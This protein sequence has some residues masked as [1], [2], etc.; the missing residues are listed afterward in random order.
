MEQRSAL[1]RCFV[2]EI[3]ELKARPP[4]QPWAAHQRDVSEGALGGSSEH[5]EVCPDPCRRQALAASCLL[6]V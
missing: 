6:S 1:L 3:R 2:V 4:A 5:V